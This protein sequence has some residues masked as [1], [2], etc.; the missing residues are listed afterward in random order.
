VEQWTCLVGLEC[1]VDSRKSVKDKEDECR[2]ER[3]HAEDTM[4]CR[5]EE[6]PNDRRL[7]DRFQDSENVKEHTS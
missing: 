1:V 2:E 7:L 5:V 4:G 6:S 3:R